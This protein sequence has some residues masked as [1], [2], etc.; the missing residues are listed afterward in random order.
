MGLLKNLFLLG[1]GAVAG[2]LAY[3]NKEQIKEMGQKAA[4]AAKEK[5]NEFSNDDQTANAQ[6]NGEQAEGN[7][8]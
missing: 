1:A 6:S 7:N 4:N 5:I 2:I 3:K 8:A